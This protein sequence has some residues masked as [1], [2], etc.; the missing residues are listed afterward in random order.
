MVPISPM[1][2]YV[3]VSRDWKWTR[4]LRPGLIVAAVR[5]V[6]LA[7]RSTRAEATS[8]AGKPPRD[9]DAK[10]AG[11]MGPRRWLSYF[12]AAGFRTTGFFAGA[13]E[14]FSAGFRATGFCSPSNTF[15]SSEL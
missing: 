7:L 2:L 1:G 3:V 10:F 13:G 8:E 14:R 11:A 9:D 15:R 5:W 12:R 4:A 6:R